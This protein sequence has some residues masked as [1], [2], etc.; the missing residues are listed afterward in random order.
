M[1]VV[2]ILSI[3]PQQTRL[4]TC[5]VVLCGGLPCLSNEGNKPNTK[6]LLVG[7]EGLFCMGIRQLHPSFAPGYWW[8]Y[9][10]KFS[11]VGF[12]S[13]SSQLSQL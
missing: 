7:W 13:F 10:C 5:L 6:S 8:L 3:P 4:K 11:K 12:F 9:L 1:D 2:I